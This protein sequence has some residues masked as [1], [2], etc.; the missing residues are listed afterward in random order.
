MA[1]NKISSKTSTEKL[2]NIIS[3][4]N[5]RRL[6]VF[7]RNNVTFFLLTFPTETSRDMTMAEEMFIE[8]SSMAIDGYDWEERKDESANSEVSDGNGQATINSN[9]IGHQNQRKDWQQ[10]MGKSESAENSFPFTSLYRVKTPVRFMKPRSGRPRSASANSKS[11]AGIGRTDSKDSLS[12]TPT[13]MG[14]EDPRR[15][16][17]VK[18]SRR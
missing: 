13:T 4:R 12:S 17:D 1:N 16:L 15:L 7:G 5:A 9:S 10:T 8:D 14:S 11:D 18:L 6:G 2:N 3:A